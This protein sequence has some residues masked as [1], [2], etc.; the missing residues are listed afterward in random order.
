MT[1]VD[2]LVPV[3]VFVAAG[4]PIQAPVAGPPWGDIRRKELI[5]A[6]STYPAP[7]YQAGI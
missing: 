5:K 3:I 6:N 7:I 2:T 4:E 1:H